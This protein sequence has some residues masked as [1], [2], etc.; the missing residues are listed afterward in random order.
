VK[1]LCVLGKYNYGDPSRG[2]GY[3]FSNF[4]PALRA[5]GHEVLHFDSWDRS[6]HR[7]FADLNRA[8]L[9]LVALERPEMIFCVLLGYEVWTETLDII[10]ASGSTTIINWGTDDSWK[11][12]QFSRFIAPHVDSYAT[13]DPKAFEKAHQHGLNNFLLTQW[14]ASRDRLVDPL[15][16]KDCKYPVSFVGSAYGNRKKWIAALRARGI[17]VECFGHGWPSGAIAAEEVPR[18]YRESVVTLNF[19]DSGLHIKG[20][21]PY[22][23]RQIKARAFEVP[24]AGGFL[25]TENAEGL[26]HF[27]RVGEEMVVYEGMSNLTDKIAYFLSH[28]EERDRIAVAGHVRTRREHTYEARF[29]SLLATVP[30]HKKSPVGEQSDIDSKGFGALAGS[31]QIGLLLKFVRF[32]FLIPCIGAWGWKRGPRAARRVVFELSWRLCGKKTYSAS[33]LVGRMFYRVS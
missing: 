16:A 21:F 30:K 2:E 29:A 19:A 5:L 24:G 22:R 18:I 15:P 31:H 11:Y 14:A 9:R 20:L 25:L 17:K 32:V 6:A 4:L 28:K 33:G 12:E 27:Y 8:L 23:S 10:R 26:D 7:D 13:T 3:E 1:I